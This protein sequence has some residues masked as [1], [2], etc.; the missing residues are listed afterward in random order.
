MSRP[1]T[2]KMEK[3][4]I[5]IFYGVE[6]T[7]QEN[8]FPW[9]KKELK[10]S[11]YQVI[12]PPL[13]TPQK[14]T[15]KDWLKAFEPYKKHLNSESIF[16]GH[17]LGVLFTLN[18]I[19]KFKIKAAYLVAGFGKLPGNKFDEGMKTFAKKFDWK[20]IRQ[21][22]KK[23]YVFA[24]DNDPYVKLTISKDLS[25]KTQTDL[26][27]VPN[28]GHLNQSAGFKKFPLLLEKI[29]NVITP[30]LKAKSHSPF[31]IEEVT[32]EKGEI[33]EITPDM[34]IGD[35]VLAFPETL[36]VLQNIGIHCIGC[37]AATFESIQ[38]GVTKHG[39][40]PKKVCK[41]LNKAIRNELR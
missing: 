25:K 39:L 5:F 27:L 19:E 12:I 8:W 15:L 31:Q 10:G 24:G 14:Q 35:V 3:P 37:Y 28:G 21:N 1:A 13:P 30:S 40:D 9:L 23:F 2:R 41:E 20:K 22:C 32:F 6:G 33:I 4:T 29:Q 26:I 7:P 38:E 16:I 34:I 11:R 36:P 17:S 18:L